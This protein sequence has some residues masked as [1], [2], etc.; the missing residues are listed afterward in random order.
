MNPGSTDSAIRAGDQQPLKG[1]ELRSFI[2]SRGE[3]QLSLIEVEVPVPTADEVVVRIEAAPLN[4]SDIGLLLGPA[5]LTSVAVSGS[6]RHRTLSAKIPAE[7]MGGLALR[8]DRSLAIGNEGAGVVVQAGPEATDLIGK[9]VSVAGG[10]MYTQY[11]RLGKAQCLVLNDGVAPIEGAAAFINPL[12]ALGMVET[13]RREGHQALVHTAAAS[14]LGRMLVKICQSEGIPLVNVVR[15][16]TQVQVLKDLGAQH[17]LNSE[18]PA[19]DAE[20]TDVLVGT[21]ATLCFDAIS[22]GP[23]AGRILL[24]MEKALSQTLPTYSRYGSSTHKQVYLYGT[25][26]PRPIEIPRV[27]MAWGVGGWLLFHFLS[28][29]GP[30]ATQSLRDKVNA[31]LRT[32]FR[33]EF[34]AEISLSD[35]LSAE[36]LHEYAKRSTG[37]KLVINPTRDV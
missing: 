18:S 31:E 22:G 13:M 33:S 21:R 9:T 3:L 29:I 26:D 8:L 34:K 7:A 37:A 14:N 2:T 24:A 30:S 1:L 32:T 19:F 16:E 25:L 6:S 28:K 20:L 4:P 23:L 10:A 15:S 5:D 35:V 36:M 12:T 11:R 17:V 27:G